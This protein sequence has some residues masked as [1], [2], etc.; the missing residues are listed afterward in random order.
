LLTVIVP[1]HPNR[2]EAIAGVVAA[3]RVC[4]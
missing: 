1:R 2:G 4:T 3:V